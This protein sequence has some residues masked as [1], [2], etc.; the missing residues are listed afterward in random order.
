M[1]GSAGILAKSRF[2]SPIPAIFA[3]V[4]DTNRGIDDGVG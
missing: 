1:G 2:V 3:D 4:G